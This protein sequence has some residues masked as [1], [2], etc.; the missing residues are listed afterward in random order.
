VAQIACP[1][2]ADAMCRLYGTDLYTIDAVMDASGRYV[3]AGL[4]CPPTAKGLACVFVPHVPHYVLRLVDASTIETLPDT[5][6]G[7]T[8][9]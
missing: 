6:I 8:V 5:L 7:A 1:T 2:D 3:A 9:P 4:D